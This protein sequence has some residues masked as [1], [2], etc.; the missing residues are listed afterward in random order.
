M[1]D[2]FYKIKASLKGDKSNNRKFKK[3]F[4]IQKGIYQFIK[5]KIKKK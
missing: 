5:I 4:K 1:I 2:K 3:I